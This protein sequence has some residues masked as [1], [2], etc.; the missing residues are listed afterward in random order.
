VS[1]GEYG[2]LKFTILSLFPQMLESYFAS[3]IMGKAVDRGL[4]EYELVDIRD[5]ASD[6]HRT[7]DDAP[8]GGGYG[9]V[10]KPEP[11]AS[12]LDS[13][14]AGAKRVVYA[15][16][17]GR[18]FDQQT[19]VE[20]SHER[21]LV[22]ICGRYEGIDQRVIDMYV[23][24]QLSIGDY[25]VSSGEIASLVIV[26]AIYRLVNG[27]ITA[28]SLEEESHNESLLEYPHYTRPEVFR[29]RGV[30]QVLLSGH[31]GEIQR[32]RRWK[33]IERTAAVRPDL[34]AR[35]GVG[36]SERR[37]LETRYGGHDGSDQ[38]D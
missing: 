8:Y 17:A 32:W 15:S 10:L 27:V 16:P 38:G 20:L 29:G 25:V 28:G 37:E 26:D 34:L 36:E 3:S 31:H 1:S 19:A 33:Q 18:L 21:E 13:V 11:L 2:G 14:D 6:R 7:A 22:M 23:H 24:D 4:I 35:S 5:F 12:A 30:P 9:M